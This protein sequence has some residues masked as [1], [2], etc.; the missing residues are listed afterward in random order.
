LYNAVQQHLTG[1]NDFDFYTHHG[2]LDE[3][4]FVVGSGIMKN[5]VRN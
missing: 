5:K 3:S 4:S 1:D 2:L